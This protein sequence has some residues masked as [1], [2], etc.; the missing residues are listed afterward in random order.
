MTSLLTMEDER[1]EELDCIAA[2]FP[3]IL[4]D[5][6]NPF[7]VSMEIPVHPTS[8]VKVLFPASSDGLVPT[9]PL[10]THS[11]Q[12]GKTA[13]VPAN[14]VESQNL[15]YLPSLQLRIT[16][17]E[18]YPE[19]KAPVFELS[20]TPAW[21]SRKHLDE[22]QGKGEEMW[23]EAGRSSV[24]YGYIDFLQQEAE[25]AFG[26]AEGGNL[27]VPQDFKISLL[28]YDIK[29]TQAA[30]EKETFDCGVCLGRQPVWEALCTY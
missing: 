15:S 23:E 13:M 30:F 22:L 28:D 11:G 9:P 5:P 19:K 6:K 1:Q 10:S 24:V 26:F 2:I 17:P 20:A 8:P 14:A 4:V 12:E 21:L 7:S 25:H 27:E 3:E 16:L 18:E 29:A